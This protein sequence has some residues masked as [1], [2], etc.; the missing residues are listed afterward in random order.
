[1]AGPALDW[2]IYRALALGFLALK[3]VLLVAA[4]PFM[5]ETYYWLWGQHLSLSNFDHP[6]LVGWTQALAS[7]L[8][9]NIVG[10]RA[11]AFLTLIGDLALLYG[12]A[13]HIGGAAWRR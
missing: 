9:W 13:R 10:L 8:G 3:L 6:P 7:V 12:F 5:D 1:M 11:F 4:R 2:R